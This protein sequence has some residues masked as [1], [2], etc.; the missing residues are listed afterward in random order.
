[1][2]VF[3]VVYKAEF[4]NEVFDNVYVYDTFNKS[5]ECF[6]DIIYGWFNEELF[7][8]KLPNGETAEWNDE[9]YFGMYQNTKNDAYLRIE[10]TNNV[11]NYLS[12]RVERHKVM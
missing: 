8:V 11:A 4:D 10:E 12:V 5:K 6:E 1:M 9:N 2:E 7:N 3:V